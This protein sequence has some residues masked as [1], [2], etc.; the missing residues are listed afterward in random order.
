LVRHPPQL[1]SPGGTRGAMIHFALA[2]DR[3]RRRDVLRRSASIR[4]ARVR[5]RDVLE[6]LGT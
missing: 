5:R 4:R 1:R 6:L 3:L 2:T